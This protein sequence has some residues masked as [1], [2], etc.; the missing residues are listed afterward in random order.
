M[1]STFA[2][3]IR[4]DRRSARRLLFNRA[5]CLLLILFLSSLVL[6]ERARRACPP[7]FLRE[8]A[9]AH[10][11]TGTRRPYIALLARLTLV[12]RMARA[13]SC[14]AWETADKAGCCVQPCL[15]QPLVGQSTLDL[16]AAATE[17]ARAWATRWRDVARAHCHGRRQRDAPPPS[18]PRTR[19]HRVV[20]SHA[21]AH[22][23]A[24]RRSRRSRRSRACM[25]DAVA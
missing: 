13:H 14:D 17:A 16:I 9:L 7:V 5:C 18:P 23:A 22:A 11:T 12:V 4:R 10:P 3:T 2:T 6:L 21:R 24:A 19:C 25:D 15:T 1:R 20:I 8:R